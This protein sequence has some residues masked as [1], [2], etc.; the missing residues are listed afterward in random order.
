MMYKLYDNNI[1][2]ESNDTR[3]DSDDSDNETNELYQLKFLAL[4]PLLHGVHNSGHIC[5]TLIV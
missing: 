1:S 4:Y 2:S 5:F 3:W